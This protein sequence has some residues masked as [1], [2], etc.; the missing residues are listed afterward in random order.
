MLSISF[1]VTSFSLAISGGVEGARLT[2]DHSRQYYYVLQ[3]LTLWRE[4]GEARVTATEKVDG[5]D[6]M[7]CSFV[8]AYLFL[9][10]LLILSNDALSIGDR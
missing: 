8:T 7:G 2:H 9:S 1:A 4:V 10:I 3:S 5:G 6:G